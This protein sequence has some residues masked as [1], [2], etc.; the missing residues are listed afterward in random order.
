MEF[1]ARPHAKFC[2]AR[3]GNWKSIWSG[4]N[5]RGRGDADRLPLSYTCLHII[6]KFMQ[7]SE[8]LKHNVYR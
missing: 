8:Y 2:L 7:I 3:T 4:L 1:T 6:V 5:G